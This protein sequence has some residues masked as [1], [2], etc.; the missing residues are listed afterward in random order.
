MWKRFWFGSKNT[1]LTKLTTL[2][3]RFLTMSLSVSPW[4][5]CKKKP[6]EYRFQLKVFHKPVANY[7]QRNKH[8]VSVKGVIYE[9]Y[10][11][12]PDNETY[13]TWQCCVILNLV[14]WNCRCAFILKE[15]GCL[16]RQLNKIK[17]FSY[18]I[19]VKQVIHLTQALMGILVTSIQKGEK[20]VIV[21]LAHRLVSLPPCVCLL[22]NMMDLTPAFPRRYISD[23]LLSPAAI[24]LWWWIRCRGYL[25]KF[26]FHPLRFCTY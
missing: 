2:L 1:P 4:D 8:V 16:W 11:I 6:T 13:K 18:S 20:Q 24:S 7:H 3:L 5:G 14:L 15:E 17:S 22:K 19:S 25:H 21:H 9:E 23:S 10:M 26:L 12:S